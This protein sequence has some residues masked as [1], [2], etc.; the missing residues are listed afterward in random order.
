MRWVN[1]IAIVAWLA[2]APVIAAGTRLEYTR[3]PG[4]EA[5]PEPAALRAS[6]VSR[7]GYD[8][9]SDAG[10]RVLHCQIA[11]N[12]NGLR[13]RIDVEDAQGRVAGQRVLTSKRG[14]CVDLAPALLLVMSLAARESAADAPVAPEPAPHGKVKDRASPEGEVVA[15]GRKRADRRTPEP[16]RA[17]DIAVIAPATPRR[18]LF[19]GVAFGAGALGAVCALPHPSLGA[20]GAIG[21]TRGRASLAI[22]LRFDAP[23]TLATTA[24]D[25]RLWAATG[26]LVPCAR[27]GW[28]AGCA[29]AGAGVQHGA[30]LGVA[31]ARRGS[32]AWI[33]AGHRAA[34]RVP[35]SVRTALVVHA[36]LLWIPSPIVTRLGQPPAEIWRTP[37]ASGALGVGVAHDFR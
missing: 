35:L 2:P 22:E 27:A 33:G 24:G 9:F 11:P 37:L 29:L 19:D 8:P 23:T 5:C 7:L 32:S 12:G 3:A 17:A 34:G 25:V 1:A 13:A 20:T 6:M 4:A 31:D 28:L 30:G 10:A 16:P 18:P 26:W 14:D 36:D 21:V 15:G